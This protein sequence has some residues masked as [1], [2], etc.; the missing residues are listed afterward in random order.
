MS[1]QAILFGI[2]LNVEAFIA[3]YFPQSKQLHPYKQI[4][5]NARYDLNMCAC[6]SIKAVRWQNE[7]RQ[8]KS[9]QAGLSLV[10]E[11]QRFF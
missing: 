3:Q 1:W 2:Y 7:I 8:E 5:P 10:N 9:G 4:I 6:G 11:I